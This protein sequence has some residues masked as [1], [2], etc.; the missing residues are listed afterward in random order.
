MKLDWFN[1]NGTWR[2]KRYEAIQAEQRRGLNN[3]ASMSEAFKRAYSNRIGSVIPH[4][5]LVDLVS[6][7]KKKIPHV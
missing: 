5:K 4:S 6:T 2:V 1:P 3:L 7:K